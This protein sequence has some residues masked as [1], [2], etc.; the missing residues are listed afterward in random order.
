MKQKVSEVEKCQGNQRR[1]SKRKIQ[2]FIACIAGIALSNSAQAQEAVRTSM[3]GE[4][5]AEAR[6]AAISSSGY[7]NL[8]LGRTAWNFR[9]NLGVE[10][11]DNIT[12]EPNDPEGDFI[13]RPELSTRML[14]RVT[15]QNA[16]NFAVSAGYS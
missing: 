4:E 11:N 14:W 2:F 6:Q 16:I 8:H 3:A 1:H 9:G 5:A 10:A 7:Y 15:E 13:F 12:L